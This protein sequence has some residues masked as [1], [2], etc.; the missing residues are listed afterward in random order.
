M[1]PLCYTS[2]TRGDFQALPKRTIGGQHSF[3]TGQVVSYDVVLHVYT[4]PYATFSYATEHGNG[5]HSHK[6]VDKY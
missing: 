1:S 2:G 6:I 4:Q 5:T 3:V